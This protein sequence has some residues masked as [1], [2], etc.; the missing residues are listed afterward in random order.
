[1]ISILKSKLTPRVL[2]LTDNTFGFS[3]AEAV[4]ATAFFAIIA[5]SLISTLIYINRL[6]YES[7]SRARATLLAEEGLEA[8]RNL[9]DNNFSN[10]VDATHGLSMAGN[11]WIFS[12][13]SDTIDGFSRQ[14]TISSLDSDTKKI[15]SQVSW[16]ARGNEYSLSLTDRLTNWQKIVKVIGDWS[17]TSLEASLDLSGTDDGRKI[18]VVGNYAYVVRA[19]GTPDFAV[20]DIHD[21]ANPVVVGSLSLVG[22][23]TNIFVSGG[24]AYVSSD[25][26]NGELKIINI[27]NSSAPTLAGTYNAPGN[28]GGNG[29]YVVGNTAYLGRTNSGSNPGFLI[30]DATNPASPTLLGSMNL[31][32]IVYEVVVS[33]DYA[34]L[35]T[36]D[37]NFE[38]RVVNI[39]NPASLSYAGSL[40]LSTNTDA[41]TIA[42]SGNTLF[43]G[44][45][46]TLHLVNITTPTAPSLLG[47]LLVAGT[48][49]DIALD[50][51]DNKYVFIATGDPNNEFKVIDITNPGTPVIF[52]QYDLTDINSLL[53]IAYDSTLDRAL[54]V[55]QADSQE[56]VIISPH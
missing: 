47:S 3:V 41:T 12:G 45:G 15:I 36:G 20:I 52:G 17:T 21:P 51:G 9:R 43:I 16:T 10:L 39:N 37:N 48:L 30:I 28:G 27:A 33:G 8:A 29:I 35:A 13:A 4:V 34:Y 22:G 56:F 31:G 14:L 38:L 40:N 23:P 25:D 11:Q 2:S 54:V 44:Q 19:D 49:N 53:G 1:M 5:T 6:A 32:K 55:G 42:V 50:L 26:N 18:Q 7:G 46:S 24:Y